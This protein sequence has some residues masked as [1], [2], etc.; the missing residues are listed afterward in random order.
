MLLHTHLSDHRMWAGLAAAL[1]DHRVTAYDMRGFGGSAQ[2]TGG[3]R[4]VDDLAQV[5]D[6]CG[7]R[8][9]VLIGN[10][11]G[12]KVALDFANREPDRVPG[13]VLLSSCYED[14]DI[15]HALAEHTT[16]L[17]TDLARGDLDAAATR[18]L[19]TWV[20]GEG[21]DW[22]PPLRSA[23]AALDR[24][25]RL[26]LLSQRAREVHALPYHWPPVEGRLGHL[27]VPVMVGIG[28]HDVIDHRHAALVLAGGL[29]HARMRCY[30][31]AGHHLLIE[32][33]V[34]VIADIVRF[35]ARLRQGG[36][37]QPR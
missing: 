18:A 24:T 11:L 33:P 1:P 16:A 12:A 17:R 7:V 15:S 6:A 10:G 30:P 13:L 25:T 14:L 20:R 36:R 28:G 32:D 19:D 23:A 9:A 5:M 35:L 4:H 34:R 37:A 2:P 26:A 21:R 27:D 22:T 8:E 31:A 3:F 29:P